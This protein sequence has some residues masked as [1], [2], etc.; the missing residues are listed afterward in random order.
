LAAVRPLLRALPA[1]ALT[2][3]LPHCKGD[4]GP[5]P[6]GM[7][8]LGGMGGGGTGGFGGAPPIEITRTLGQD[9]GELRTESAILSVPSGALDRNTELRVTNLQAQEVEVLPQTSG[10]V[11]LIGFPSKFTPHGLSFDQPVDVSLKYPPPE[12]EA[13]PVVAM[14]LENDQDTTWEFVPDGKF[15]SGTASFKID[16]FSIYACFED[17]ENVAE[18]L[19]APEG[20]GTGGAGSGGETAAGGS[21]AGGSSAGGSGGGTAGGGGAPSGGAGGS[22]GASGGSASGGGG[23]SGGGTGING[24]LDTPTFQGFGAYEPGPSATIDGDLYTSPGPNCATG[25]VGAN[26]DSYASLVYFAN[27]GTDAVDLGPIL[28]PEGGLHVQLTGA[29]YSSVYHLVEL[30]GDSGAWCAP[31]I[32]ETSSVQFIPWEDFD[33]NNCPN[34]P[35]VDPFDPVADTIRHVAI[36]VTS[37][38]EVPGSFDYCLGELTAGLPNGYMNGPSWSGYGFVEYFYS[39]PSSTDLGDG[40]FPNCIVGSTAANTLDYAGLG[41]YLD[42]TTGGT[43]PNPVTVQEAGLEVDVLMSISPRD[44]EVRLRGI[45]ADYCESLPAAGTGTF[46]VPWGDFIDCDGTAPFVPGNEQVEAISVNVLSSGV[47]DPYDLCVERLEATTP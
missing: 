37:T 32:G 36:T 43:G 25:T 34:N 16:S 15:E 22:G 10:G 44:V 6:D 47:T 5:G 24:Y 3:L 4:E 29:S 20:G 45:N 21:S 12:D 19:Y 17:P 1:L 13:T 2:L 33:A 11:K 38:G 31:L 27:Q 26:S 18:M 40:P 35:P 42:Q 41:Y 23:G 39:Y 8:G 30:R 28:M 46:Y 14:K 9:G 7:G